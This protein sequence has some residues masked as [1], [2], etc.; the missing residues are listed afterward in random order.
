MVCLI[1]HVPVVMQN[2][3]SELKERL[4]KGV[5]GDI[6]NYPFKEFDTILEMEK[7]DVAPAEEEE[8]VS[9]VTECRLAHLTLHELSIYHGFTC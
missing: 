3:E 7:D 5:Y 9:I 6:Y 2:I 4:K 8:E 1:E